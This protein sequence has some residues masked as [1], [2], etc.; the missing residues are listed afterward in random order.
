MP[1]ENCHAFITCLA[2]TATATAAAFA[3]V[4]ICGADLFS[5]NKSN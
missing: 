4:A 3:G 1:L 5:L 2:Y